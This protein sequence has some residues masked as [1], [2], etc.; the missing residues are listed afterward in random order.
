MAQSSIGTTRTI[1]AAI[2]NE[3]LEKLTDFEELVDVVGN[4]AVITKLLVQVAADCM[5]LTVLVIF[6]FAIV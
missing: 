3:G 6:A 5:K 1:I 4:V 2:I